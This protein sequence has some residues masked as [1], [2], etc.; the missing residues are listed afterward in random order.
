LKLSKFGPRGVRA[1]ASPRSRRRE[2]SDAYVLF[3]A[4]N[5][6]GVLFTMKSE[7]AAGGDLGNDYGISLTKLN[8]D[9]RIAIRVVDRSGSVLA[10]VVDPGGYAGLAVAVAGDAT[11]S[12]LL[13]MRLTGSIPNSQAFSSSIGDYTSF[14]GG[15]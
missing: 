3:R 4:A 5:G 14:V 2:L 10:T 13:T 1:V 11:V 12:A 9:G 6:E 15:S 7:G 8:E